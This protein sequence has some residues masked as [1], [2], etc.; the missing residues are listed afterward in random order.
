MVFHFPDSAQI[1]LPALMGMPDTWDFSPHVFREHVQA[2][3][4][5]LGIP[6]IQTTAYG[7]FSSPIPVPWVSFGILLARQPALWRYFFQAP[8]AVVTAPYYDDTQIVDAAGNILARHSEAVEGF[9]LSEI[10][11]AD[12]PPLFPGQPPA[13]RN[14][15]QRL[16]LFQDVLSWSMLPT[17]RRGV[18]RVWGRAMAPV[19]DQT[20]VWGWFVL[21]AS[22]FAFLAGWFISRRE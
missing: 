13:W 1:S 3:A 21:I 15:A 8:K 14:A 7:Q 9:A 10:T 11:L 5:W 16:A 17:Y 20:Q 18:R 6:V 2:C 19:D 22:L 12:T 4:A